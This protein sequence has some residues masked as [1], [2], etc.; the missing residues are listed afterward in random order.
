MACR[1]AFSRE[2]RRQ[3]GSLPG[4]IKALAKQEIAGL[5]DDPRP[6]QSKKV[7]IP[8]LWHQGAVSR[9]P[10]CASSINRS[11]WSFFSFLRGSF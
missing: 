4:H 1:I 7:L 2:V 9:L 8:E 5:S 11:T 10:R 6:P 3:I